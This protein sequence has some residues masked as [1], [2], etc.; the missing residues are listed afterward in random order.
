MKYLFGFILL[1]HGLFHIVGFVNAFYITDISK[2][3]LGIPKPFGTLWLITFILFAVTASQFLNNKKWFYLGITAVFVSQALIIMAWKDAKLGTILNLIILLVGISAY[4]KYRFQ[5]MVDKES[6]EMYNGISKNITKVISEKDLNQLPNIIQTWLR[7]SGIIG[8]KE[9]VTVRLKQKGKMRTTPNSKW[10]PFVATQ[11][12]NTKSPSFVWS[13][14][15]HFSSII[16]MIGR[17][18][19]LDGNGEV[20]IKLASLIPVVNE[21]QNIRINSGS[22]IRYLAEICWFPSAALNNCI[23]WE[24]INTTSAKATFTYKDTSVSGIFSFNDEGDLVSF[25][26]QRYFSGNIEAKLES[27]LVETVTFK[28]FNGIRIPSENKVTWKLSDG[29][30]NWLNIEIT[31]LEFN[32]PNCYKC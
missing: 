3:V 14:T 15:V 10:K 2:Q 7:H 13:T 12:F 23:T 19:L 4:G 28:T 5:K 30:F 18:K 8:K 17:D 31:D 16:K 11:C 25:E 29:D 21:S 32:Q 24:S 9:I 6:K 1:I 26:A 22:M 27:W 20:L